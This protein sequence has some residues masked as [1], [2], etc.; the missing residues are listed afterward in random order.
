MDTEEIKSWLLWIMYQWTWAYTD[1]SVRSLLH[2]L[3]IYTNIP[4]H[5]HLIFNFWKSSMLF[6]I[7]ATPIYIPTN[8]VQDSLFSTSLP[9]RVNSCLLYSRHFNRWEVIPHCSF[10]SHIPHDYWCWAL[11]HES[12][13][14]VYIFLG[15]KMSLPIL[16]SFLN[17]S[18]WIDFAI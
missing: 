2:F 9:I 4:Y 10:D 14:H 5:S 3:W 8:S 12:I 17:F 11:F 15:E 1:I 13:D 18:V 6:S 7:R 16:G